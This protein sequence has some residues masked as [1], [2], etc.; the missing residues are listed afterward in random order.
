LADLYKLAAGLGKASAVDPQTQLTANLPGYQGLTQAASANIASDLAGQVPQDVINLLWQQSAERGAGQGLGPMAPNTNA[1]YLRALGLTSMGLKAQGQQELT[2]AIGRTPTGPLF[3]PSSMLVSPAAQQA[4]Q[5][6]ANT[7]GA[8]PIP[9]SAAATN[10]AALT[11][12]LNQGRGALSGGDW[13][14]ASGVNP[15][16]PFYSPQELAGGGFPFNPPGATTGQP[17]DP[18]SDPGSWMEIPGTNMYENI[19][20]GETMDMG[21]AMGGGGMTTQWQPGMELPPGTDTSGQGTDLFQGLGTDQYLP[22]DFS[23][24]LG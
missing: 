15:A 23:Q 16:Q 8:A 7:L 2:G 21:G 10:L 24:M 11:R 6:A 1:A 13:L 17:S 9:A 3:D 18:N 22:T 12:G 5:E 19:Y 14:A 20:T 4:A